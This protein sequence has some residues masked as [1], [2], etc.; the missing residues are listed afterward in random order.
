MAAEASVYMSASQSVAS[1]TDAV[2]DLDAEVFDVGAMH[3]PST[4]PSR[5]TVPAGEAGYYVVVAQLAWDNGAG[6]RELRLALLKNGTVVARDLAGGNVGAGGV[7][8]RIVAVLSL[9]VA[10]YLQIQAY[11]TGD[12]FS[13]IGGASYTFLQAIKVA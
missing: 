6:T 9:A 8:N 7:F 11:Q 10:D 13:V 2:L 12:A 5:L 3:D 1:V 4:N